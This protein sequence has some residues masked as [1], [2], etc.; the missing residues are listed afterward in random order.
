MAITF[1]KLLAAVC[2]VCLLTG[3]L[4][5][6]SGGDGNTT[7]STSSSTLESMA[8]ADNTWR[9]ALPSNENTTETDVYETQTQVSASIPAGVTL[10]KTTTFGSSGNDMF[11]RVAATADGGYAAIG[12]FG[13]ANGD[14]EDG[15]KSWS[16]TKSM[17]VKYDKDGQVQWKAF[18][19][20]DNDGVIF[21]GL[22]QLADKSFIVVGYTNSSDL[23]VKANSVADALMLKYSAEGKL[24][25]TKLVGGSQY[26]ELYS[27]SATTDGGFV[28]GGTTESS[29][30][31]FAGLKA[32]AR[33][34]VLIKF[35]GNGEPRWKRSMSGSMYNSFENIAVNSSGDI[36]AACITVSNDG[37]FAKIAGRGEKDTVA[38]KYDKNG[39]FKWAKSFSGS[40]P[41]ELSA[42]A[43]S[44]DGGCVIAGKY[45]IMAK[46]DGSFDPYHNAGSYDAFLVKYNSNGSIGWA[47]PFAG[48][49]N[50]EITGITPVN[51]GYAA[52]GMSES[53]NRDFAGLGNKGKSDGFVL[54]LDELGEIKGSLPLS[55]ALVDVPRAVTCLDGS[56]IFVAGGTQSSDNTFNGLTP[57]ASNNTFICFTAILSASFK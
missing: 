5:G 41:D 19:G 35:D 52:V 9:D 46:T 38:F 20:G 21:N 27:V 6:C 36:F 28:A 32:N 55:G 54:L 14:C 53:N 50:D 33:K 8:P 49:L 37:D 24:E 23:G 43:C 7:G 1:R 12:F 31:Y 34:A 22:A 57:A 29:D 18:L 25:W 45:A 26:D 30:G 48:F 4:T 13:T 56:R 15:K 51:G 39:A 3:I 2:A 16:G 47:K 42:I 17:L 44:P 40:G 10:D 11:E